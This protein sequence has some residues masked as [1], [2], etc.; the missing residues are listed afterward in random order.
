MTRAKSKV[1]QIEF[2]K[3]LEESEPMDNLPSIFIRK[4]GVYEQNESGCLFRCFTLCFLHVA[5]CSLLL[6][7]WVSR[8]CSH[9]LKVR[10]PSYVPPV[11]THTTIEHVVEV[12]EVAPSIQ[13]A[14][15]VH[16][17]EPGPWTA[18]VHMFP[19]GQNKSTRV[20]VTFFAGETHIDDSSG[21]HHR[22]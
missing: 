18:N 20:S 21:N 3:Q 1:C 8:C 10:T 22:A 17:P 4:L 15:V 9:Y 5:L 12:P 11:M 2:L 14:N 7:S 19:K 13:T 6:R 16:F